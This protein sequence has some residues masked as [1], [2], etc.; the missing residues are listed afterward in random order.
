MREKS[1]RRGKESI[2]SKVADP[3]QKGGEKG[4]FDGVGKEASPTEGIILL[5]SEEREIL[6]PDGGGES[7]LRKRN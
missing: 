1:C 7:F 2:S 6:L 4:G 5:I 3:M